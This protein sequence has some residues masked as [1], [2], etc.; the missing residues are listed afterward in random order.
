MQPR[1]QQLDDDLAER[2]ITEAKTV[3]AEVGVDINDEQTRSLLADHGAGGDGADGRVR[4]GESMVEAA[5]SSAPQSFSLYDVLGEETHVFEG[6]R[7]H[8]T[9][10]SAAINILDR[11]SGE[12][13]P[14][15][16]SDLVALA[17]LVSGLERYDAQSTALVASGVT[18]LG[19]RPVPPVVSRRSQS[20]WSQRRTSASAIGPV[21]SGTLSR[22]ASR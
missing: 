10:G 11:A 5:L 21:S 7:T 3:L 12:I 4:I 1:F 20:S 6:R 8:F 19:V 18:S 17:R 14:A 22:S 9:P 2:I 16:T 13:R 15:V